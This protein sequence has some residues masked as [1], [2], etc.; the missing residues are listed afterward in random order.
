[1]RAERRRE[2]HVAD[3]MDIDDVHEHVG[4]VLFVPDQSA[5]AVDQDV[6]CL[7]PCGESFD[8]RRA[9]Y[10]DFL[11]GEACVLRGRPQVADRDLP[12]AV[13]KSRCKGGSKSAG[14]TA[15]KDVLTC[16]SKIRLRHLPIAVALRSSQPWPFAF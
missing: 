10:V 6:E 15:Y 14:A 13:S 4:F 7:D 12:T 5:G 3:K 8:G 2:T 11:E 1:M 16:H 9:P